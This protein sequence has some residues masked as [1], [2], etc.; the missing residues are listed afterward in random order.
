[1]IDLPTL[2]AILAL[3][4]LLMLIVSL[5]YWMLHNT[6]RNIREEWQNGICNFRADMLD[7]MNVRMDH[8]TNQMNARIDQS[9]DQMNAR[10]DHLTDQMNARMDHLTDQ[11][12][13]RMDH[14]T[15]QMNARIDRSND[16]MNARMDR[17]S[18]RMDQLSDH[19]HQLSDQMDRNHREIL[20]LLENHTHA[21]GT[22]AVFHQ[23]TVGDSDS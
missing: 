10:M 2:Q 7:Q 16:Q 11:M 15:D 6:E 8:L 21:D 4:A 22:P 18:D 19:M 17:L 20:A 14:L 5:F 9:S 13:A 1:M 3:G 23:V 12:N